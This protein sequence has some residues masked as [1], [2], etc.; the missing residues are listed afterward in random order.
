MIKILTELTV[1][2]VPEYNE[3]RFGKLQI[4]NQKLA[5]RVGKKMH[6]VVIACDV[7]D[8]EGEKRLQKIY[9]NLKE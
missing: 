4:S 8:E 6:V 3:K 7:G 5:D 2:K 1:G 9:R